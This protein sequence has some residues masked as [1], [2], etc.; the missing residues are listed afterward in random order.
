MPGYSDF[1]RSTIETFHAQRGKG[2][3]RWG[4]HLLL[5]TTVGA[6]SG[7]PSIT[8]V[9]FVRDGE[10]YVVMA[11]MGGAPRNPGW[12]H[13]L[14]SNPVVTLEVETE[15]FRARASVAEGAERDRLFKVLG[16]VWPGFYDY[17]KKTT[18]VMPVVVLEPIAA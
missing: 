15:K 3:G 16:E 14:V 6:K 4:D 8:P 12:Y 13:N 7:R 1:N 9:V 5:L 2:I 10:R 18:R 17:E 11:S